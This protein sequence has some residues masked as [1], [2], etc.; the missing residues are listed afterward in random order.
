MTVQHLS[1]GAVDKSIGIDVSGDEQLQRVSAVS[2]SVRTGDLK[3]LQAFR[4]IANRAMLPGS[5]CVSHQRLTTC[6]HRNRRP[7][8]LPSL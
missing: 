1:V 6:D 7:Q 2:C 3:L 8:L 4:S 5:P